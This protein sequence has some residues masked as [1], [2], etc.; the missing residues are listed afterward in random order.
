MFVCACAAS[1]PASLDAGLGSDMKDVIGFRRVYTRM[2]GRV[3]G[4][5]WGSA[6]RRDG[7]SLEMEL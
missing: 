2:I 4:G 5:I 3:N 7:W 1:G 6:D